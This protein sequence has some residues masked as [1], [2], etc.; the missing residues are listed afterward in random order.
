[1]GGSLSDWN[2]REGDGIIEGIVGQYGGPGRYEYREL[3]LDMCAERK[4]VVGN[5]LFKK[6]DVYIYY[7]H[8]GE[9]VLG[10]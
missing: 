4:F 6:K 2:A 10:G 9:K 3:L 8:M 1:M 7:I 5:S